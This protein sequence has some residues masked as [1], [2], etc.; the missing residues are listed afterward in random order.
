VSTVYYTAFTAISPGENGLA[1]R[2]LDPD[3]RL[4]QFLSVARCAFSGFFKKVTST[5]THQTLFFLRPQNGSFDTLGHPS[6][7]A[8]K[9]TN[10][11]LRNHTNAPSTQK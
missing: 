2:P 5:T 6:Q 8:Q 4:V 1:S 10:H 11:F 9:A 7:T 3:G